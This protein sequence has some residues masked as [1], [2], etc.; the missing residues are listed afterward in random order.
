[1][2]KEEE[3]LNQ[4]TYKIIP[5]NPIT[6]QKNKLKSLQNSIKA[7]GG[8]NEDTYRKMYPTGADTPKFYGLP[9]IHRTGGPQR[10]T[11]S[12]RGAVSYETAKELARILK[13]LVG[14]SPYNVHNIRD[15]VQ[16]M[17]NIQ[18]QQ[19]ECIISYN[20]KAVLVSYA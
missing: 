17:K 14:K 8:I 6:K 19:H 5:A 13:P 3:F 16:Q 20:V 1:M 9:K 18:L 7:V 15:F 10:P 2:K 12:S 11:F 4:E